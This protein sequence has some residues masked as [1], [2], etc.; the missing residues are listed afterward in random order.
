M[1][2]FALIL[3]CVIQI[4]ALNKTIE[5]R[6]FKIKF[7]RNLNE[8]EDARRFK[9]FEENLLMIQKHNELE[10]KGSETFRLGINRYVDMTFE[11]I[12]NIH[13]PADYSELDGF[14][15]IKSEW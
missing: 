11:E 2:I 4:N 5:W 9:I 15:G 7:K 3:C 13:I 1:K 8:T 6:D 10:A 14:V 12:K